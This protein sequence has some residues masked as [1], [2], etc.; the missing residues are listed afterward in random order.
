MFHRW[1]GRSFWVSVKHCVFFM[2]CSG[3]D[4]KLC[5]FP[6]PPPHTI[7][8]TCWALLSV[9]AATEAASP[10]PVAWPCGSH[11]MPVEILPS[12]LWLRRAACKETEHWEGETALPTASQAVLMSPR[13]IE[14]PSGSQF[15]EWGLRMTIGIIK[16]LLLSLASWPL[17]SFWKKEREMSRN[18]AQWGREAGCAAHSLFA[19]PPHSRAILCSVLCLGAPGNSFTLCFLAPNR[20][21]AVR[22]LREATGAWR[23]EV[24]SCAAFLAC[25]SRLAPQAAPP[26]LAQ[27]SP[28]RGITVLSFIFT[29]LGWLPLPA[30]AG[31]WVPQLPLCAPLMSYLHSCMQ[32]LH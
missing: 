28:S 2:V 25:P 22:K 30:G 12:Y 15:T 4:L 16:F 10:F 29:A 32:P 8:P 24:P 7:P 14:A 18:G 9:K 5:P 3:N 23:A 6:R 27:R 1:K 20:I 13:T 17:I 21:Q 26:P 31:L 19:P 11:R